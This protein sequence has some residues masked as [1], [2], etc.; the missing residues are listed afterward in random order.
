MPH[1]TGGKIT[2]SHTTV[3][4]ATGIVVDAAS[5]RPEVTKIV[6]GVIQSKRGS[7]R[8][9]TFDI[10]AGLRVTVVST[11]SIQELYVYTADQRATAAALHAAWPG[12][13]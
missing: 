8:L 12:S 11:G 3:T 7:R 5:R 10:A 9:K 6:L 1:R 13:G 2:G 4:E